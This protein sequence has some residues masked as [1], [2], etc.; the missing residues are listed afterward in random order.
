MNIMFIG[1]K[2]YCVSRKKMYKIHIQ[3]IA[4][5]LIFSSC[6]NEGYL[7]KCEHKNLETGISIVQSDSILNL[8]ELEADLE[9]SNY[10]TSD[11][12]RELIVCELN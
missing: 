11:N 5:V 2:D 7:C 3:I 8:S 10:A 12:D 6:S 4:V 9:C 1:I